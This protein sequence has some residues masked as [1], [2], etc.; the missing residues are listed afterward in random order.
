MV[1]ALVNPDG[2]GCQ[3]MGVNNPFGPRLA[4]NRDGKLTL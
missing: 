3:L 2:S 1:T 4:A